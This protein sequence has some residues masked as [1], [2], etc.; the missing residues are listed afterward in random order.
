MQTLLTDVPQIS[1]PL[2]RPVILAFYQMDWFQ[3]ANF[4]ALEQLR[5]T[6]LHYDHWRD[7]LSHTKSGTVLKTVLKDLYDRIIWRMPNPGPKLNDRA[8]LDFHAPYVREVLLHLKPEIIIA[9]GPSAHSVVGQEI[10]SVPFTGEA[11]F[12]KHPLEPEALN[13]LVELASQLRKELAH[14]EQ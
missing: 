2:E 1:S 14:Y 10:S 3:K 13:S 5:R 6:Y 8:E 4:K 11:F 12:S 9:L 7:M